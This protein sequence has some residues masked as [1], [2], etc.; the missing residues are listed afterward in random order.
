MAR[1]VSAPLEELLPGEQESFKGGDRWSLPTTSSDVP[2]HHGSRWN[3]VLSA[4]Q[5]CCRRLLGDDPEAIRCFK[6]QGPRSWVIYRL[7]ARTCRGSFLVF[8]IT[9]DGRLLTFPPGRRR[10]I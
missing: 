2:C 10:W 7:E 6:E 5:D 8:W 9:A 3:H 4:I 1:R